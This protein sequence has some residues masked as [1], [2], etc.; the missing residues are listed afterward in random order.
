MVKKT[1]KAK[2]QIISD[3]VKTVESMKIVTE[4]PVEK[5]NDNLNVKVLDQK[6]ELLKNEVTENKLYLELCFVSLLILIFG[7]FRSDVGQETI[8][9]GSVFGKVIIAITVGLYFGIV[10]FFYSIIRYN[11]KN[12]QMINEKIDSILKK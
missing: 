3:E 12:K 1:I 2:E 10:F 7:Y 8:R 5:N 11:H 6:I 4:K 9:S